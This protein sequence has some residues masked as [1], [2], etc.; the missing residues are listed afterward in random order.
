MGPKRVIIG[1]SKIFNK[2]NISIKFFTKIPRVWLKDLFML[3]WKVIT[4]H[5]SVHSTYDLTL[6]SLLLIL[7][8]CCCAESATPEYIQR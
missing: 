4:S 5:C 8:L 1:E 7:K 2:N 3:G 6:M